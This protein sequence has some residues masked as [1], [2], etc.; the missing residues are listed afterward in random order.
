MADDS[1]FEV[2]RA[3]GKVH[4]VVFT[5]E[6]IEFFTLEPEDAKALA[7]ALTAKADQN[8]DDEEI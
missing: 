4:L 2:K 3:D 7:G 1:E 5:D 8:E 6:L